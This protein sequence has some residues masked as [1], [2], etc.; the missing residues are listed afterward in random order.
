MPRDS[1]ALLPARIRTRTGPKSGRA[2]ALMG[3]FRLSRAFLACRGGGFPSPSLMRFVIPL[4][5]EIEIPAL[6]GL[7]EQASRPALRSKLLGTRQTLLRFATRTCP[8]SSR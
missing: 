6:Q 2:V 7:P 4:S 5:E 1:R 8:Q 3:F